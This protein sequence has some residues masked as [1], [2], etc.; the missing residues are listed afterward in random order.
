MTRIELTKA[1]RPLAEYARQAQREAVVV[2]VRGRPRVAVVRLDDDVD[3]ESLSLSANPVFMDIV[4]KSR[5]SLR[6]DGGICS[7]ELRR[8][9]GIP[10]RRSRRGR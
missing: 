5:A 7:D 3:W 10:K 9:L 8:R 2:T 1:V 4:A 6:K